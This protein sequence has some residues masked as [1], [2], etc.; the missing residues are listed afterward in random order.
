MGI[1]M[2]LEFCTLSAKT[3]PVNI[4]LIA[5]GENPKGVTTRLTV[6]DTAPGPWCP[7]VLPSPDTPAV[8]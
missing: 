6:P 3:T 2:V 1:W 4:W 8:D 5:V 7:N